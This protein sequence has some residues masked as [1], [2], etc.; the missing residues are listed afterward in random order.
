MGGMGYRS[1][2]LSV[3]AFVVFMA[4][5]ARAEPWLR[6]SRR[7]IEVLHAAA[8]P[9]AFVAPTHD[10]MMLATPVR[11]PPIADL[12]MPM[13]RLAGVRVTPANNGLHNP[14]YFSDFTLVT[15]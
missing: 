2:L 11:F 3:A 9:V 14:S 13:L 5:P 6:P 10:A 1:R 8:P 15:K 12:A 4:V 7:M